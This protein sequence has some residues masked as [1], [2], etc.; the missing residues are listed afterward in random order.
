MIRYLVYRLL[1]VI[2][3]L[4]GVSLLA[5]VVVAMLPGPSTPDAPA[6]EEKRRAQFLDLPTFF[7]GNPRDVRERVGDAVQH[8]A[9]NDAKAKAAA[10]TL[11]DLG[12]A[13]LPTVIDALEHLDQSQAA[14][15]AVALAPIAERL[16]LGDP[17]DLRDAETAPRF[18]HRFWGDRAL[19]FTEPSV[20]RNLDRFLA[21]G[22]ARWEKELIALDTFA[23]PEIMRALDNKTLNPSDRARLVFLA[24]TVTAHL[25]VPRDNAVPQRDEEQLRAWWFIHRS[26]FVTYDGAERVGAF[27][28][29][30]RYARW[31]V[32][33]LTGRLG[34]STRDGEPLSTKLWHRGPITL[35][36][37]GLALLLGVSLA[38][39]L[40]A[41]SASLRGKTFDTISAVVAVGVYATP[42]FAL[43]IFFAPY[44]FDNH[45]GVLRV[46]LP[47]LVLGLA[48]AATL[49]RQQRAVMIDVLGEDYVRA[50]RSR[51]AP[52][53]RWITVH[54]LRNAMMPVISLSGIEFAGLL[55]S[56]LVVEE[57]FA[58][59]GVGWETMRA[60]EA[61]DVGWLVIAV[62]FTGVAAT[63]GL[64]VADVLHA[65]LDPKRRYRR[66]GLSDGAHA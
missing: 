6:A 17:I 44:F 9:A 12:G 20:R 37:A 43:S 2:P 54:A 52:R 66:A 61:H 1:W 28:G 4:F 24:H 8:I 26:E 10:D 62:L 25:D 33:A 58:I 14:R 45:Q 64:I 39:P 46:F 49:S 42:S 22:S 32:G 3:T 27:V 31:L 34:L 38:V 11:A 56:T 53:W 13:G 47:I 15:V 19:D 5:F 23:L 65:M 30:T 7:N 60:L 55:G 18:W 48:S 21:T 51:G 63:V 59:H 57:C 36:L 50:A 16:N 40:G 41:I 29:D 35:A